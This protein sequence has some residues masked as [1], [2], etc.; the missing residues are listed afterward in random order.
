MGNPLV[1]NKLT[2]D[3]NSK[4]KEFQSR[5]AQ[6]NSDQLCCFENITQKITQDHTH[7]HFFLQGSGRTGK[8][9]LYHTLCNF[10]HS[11]GKVVLCVASSGVA[12]LLLP[13]GHTS[14]SRFLIPIQINESVIG[15]T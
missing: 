4:L 10:Y 15:Q 7:A 5:K 13:R 12:A 11:Q 9:F 1:V 2:Y 8:I 14:H 3:T 6:L